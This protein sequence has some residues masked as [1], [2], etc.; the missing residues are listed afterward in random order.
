MDHDTFIGQVQHRARLD[1]RGAAE[2]AV[3]ATLET[4]AERL[5]GREPSHLAAQLPR[6]IG[7]HLRR[8]EPRQEQLG[9]QEFYQRV[10]DR[11]GAGVD[12]PDAIFHA[13]AVL[14][15]VR[16]AVSTGE[17]EDVTSQLPDEYAE[18]LDY[19]GAVS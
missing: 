8:E 10:A 12:L 5:A 1:S 13:K 7:M 15:V 19:E 6:E 16:D 11:S 9:L 14:S 4:L 18:L 3:R 2:T 17:F